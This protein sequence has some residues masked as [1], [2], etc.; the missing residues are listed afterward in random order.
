M[1]NFRTRKSQPHQNQELLVLGGKYVMQPCPMAGR[2]EHTF[3]QIAKN[4]FSCHRK[5]KPS[6]PESQ[7]LPTWSFLV[8]T[9]PKIL[10]K[11]GKPWSENGKES[12]THNGFLSK[13]NLNLNIKVLNYAVILYKQTLHVKCPFSILVAIQNVLA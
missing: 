1:I 9:H 10:I 12:R 2:R 11:F 6:H 4:M 3:G 5:A 13:E 8:N 7:F